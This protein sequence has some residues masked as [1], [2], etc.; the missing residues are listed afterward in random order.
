MQGEAGGAPTRSERIGSGRIRSRWWRGRAMTGAPAAV[1]ADADPRP[2][3]RHTCGRGGPRVSSGK[4]KEG[5]ARRGDLTKLL[6]GD[7]T[8]AR[9]G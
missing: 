9:W 5:E 3:G 4:G 8:P 6:T 2:T 7:D 1:L